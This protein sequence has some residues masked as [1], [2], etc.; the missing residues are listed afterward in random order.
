MSMRFFPDGECTEKVFANAVIAA[1][2]EFEEAQ[3]MF[4]AARWDTAYGSSGTIGATAEILRLNGVT[5]GQINARGLQWCRDQLLRAGNVSRLKIDGLKDDRKPVMAGGLAVLSAVFETFG[6][7]QMHA[8]DGALR[9]GVL[10]DLLGRREERTD[11]RGQTVERLQLRFGVDKAQSHR[12]EATALLLYAQIA[13]NA[14]EEDRRMLTWASALHELG[15][16]V[17]HSEFHKHGAY[18]MANADAAGF[19]Q[20]QS[21]WVADLVLG[22]RGGLRKV[23]HRL[24]DEKFV[25]QLLSLRLAALLAHARRTPE[26]KAVMLQRDGSTFTLS[27]DAQWAKHHPQSIYLL[28]EEVEAWRKSGWRLQVR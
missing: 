20:L 5:D 21:A 26:R 28:Q 11:I 1:Q 22:H 18:I 25:L 17:S 15:M 8:A 10:F 23:E 9:Q 4:E 2:A 14:E 3:D 7:E 12:V 16:A 19:S 27:A 6:I 13:S 24:A